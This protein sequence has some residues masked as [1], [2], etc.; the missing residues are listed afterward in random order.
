METLIIITVAPDL[1]RNSPRSYD[2][3]A[4]NRIRAKPVVS[5]LMSAYTPKLLAIYSRIQ[6]KLNPKHI[7]R[8]VSVN[9]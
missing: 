4:L 7:I 3:I 2:L 1:I 6:S 5:Y 9:K 8:V